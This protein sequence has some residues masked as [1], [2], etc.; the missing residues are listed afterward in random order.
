MYMYV[1]YMSTRMRTR[2]SKGNPGG[3]SLNNLQ[4]VYL[5]QYRYRRKVYSI[6]H[7]VTQCS[8]STN[9]QLPNWTLSLTL[10]LTLSP[11]FYMNVTIIVTLTC[12]LYLIVPSVID[13]SCCCAFST[14]RCWFCN[15]VVPEIK[16]ML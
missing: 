1:W 4:S 10:S 16:S 5:V 14:N 11:L 6:H 12:I 7:T 8:T 13:D 9:G 3:L 2:Y 15:T